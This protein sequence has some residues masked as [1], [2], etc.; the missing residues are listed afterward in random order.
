VFHKALGID[1]TE[2]DYKVFSICTEISRQV[3][4]VELDSNDPRFRRGMERLRRIADGIGAAK[5]QGGVI[6]KIKQVGFMAA[7]GASFARLYLLR[8]KTNAL[9]AQVRLAPA[10]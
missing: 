2:Y 3:F 6:G 1:P 5:E 4:P 7:A 9:P 8:P 10:W